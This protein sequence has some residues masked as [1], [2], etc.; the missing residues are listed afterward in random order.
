M[1]TNTTAAVTAILAHSTGSRLGT[2]V[3]DERIIPVPYSPLITRTPRT[4]IA[5]SAKLSPDRL[6]AMG[7]NCCCMTAGRESKRLPGRR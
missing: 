3:S 2:T 7:S 1:T 5:S 4:P 6:T